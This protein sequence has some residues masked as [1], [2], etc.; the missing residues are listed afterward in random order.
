MKEK[1]VPTKQ[2]EQ[3]RES[4]A[5]MARLILGDV[6][7]GATREEMQIAERVAAKVEKMRAKG[8][9]SRHVAQFAAR[10]VRKLQRAG[11]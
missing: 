9:S 4:G 7:L 11:P 2:E 3:E 10:E 1:R 8:Y 5:R 6:V